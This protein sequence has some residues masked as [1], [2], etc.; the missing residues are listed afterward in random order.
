[1]AKRSSNRERIE[2]RAQEA[3]VAAK[4]KAATK[5]TTKK[6]TTS[7]KKAAKTQ[8]MKT[9]WKVFNNN[10]K[11]VACFP[12]P[13]KDKADEKAAQLTKKTGQEHF[14]NGIKVPMADDE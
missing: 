4:E 9:V 7:R 12:Y 5:K 10:I 6:K 2:R 11:E 14:V 3:A 8:R 13:E 1:M